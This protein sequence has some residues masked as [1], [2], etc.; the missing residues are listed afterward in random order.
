[1]K[2]LYYLAPSLDSTHRISDDLR[3][4]GLD[5]CFL[6]V[7]TKDEAGLKREQIHSSNYFE[8]LILIYA[9]K[10]KEDLVRQLMR[11]K[12]PEAQHVATDRHYINP[13]SVVRRRGQRNA[14]MSQTG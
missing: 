11:D 14:D 6:Q 2:C 8:T 13:F 10:K 3:E 9:P 1:M 7:V 4:S 5:D 12:H